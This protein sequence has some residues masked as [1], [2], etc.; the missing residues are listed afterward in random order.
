MSAARGLRIRSAQGLAVLTLALAACVGVT[1]TSTRGAIG[2]LSMDR[3]GG[4]A[5]LPTCSGSNDCAAGPDICTGEDQTATVGPT[6]ITDFSA[7]LSSDGRGAYVQGTDNVQ[8]SVVLTL[9]T[10]QFAQSGKSVKNPRTYTVNLNNPVSGGGGV[11]LG[12]ITDG[13]NNHLE[14]QWYTV[15]NT[16]QNLHGIPVGQT[17]TAQQINVAF[18]LNGHFHILQMGPQ[19]YGHCH[20]APTAVV[21]TGTTSGT[22]YRA[23]AT[24]W[25][26]DLPAGSVGRLFDL[27][28][29]DQYAVDRGLYYT[30]LHFEIGN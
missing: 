2:Q 7:G 11:P 16:R 24:K 6:V 12:S 14:V 18:H 5:K 22:I 27:Y 15:G 28:N 4:G 13:N 23:S 21:G 17:V 19:P 26:I 1:D 25:V 10:L 30:Q 9:A 8:Y 29:T 3:G 20:S